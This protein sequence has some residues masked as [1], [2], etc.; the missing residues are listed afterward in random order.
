MLCGLAMG[1]AFDVY[2]VACHRFSV[3]RWTLPGLDV[4]YWALAT[5]LVFRTL[6]NNNEGEV[7]LYVFLGIGIGITGYFGLFSSPLIKAISFL[8]RVVQNT[9]RFLWRAVLV[10]FVRPVQFVV[11]MI[12]RV[13]DIAFIIVAALLLW[14]GRLALKPLAPP[15]RWIWRLLLP[16]RQALRPVGDAWRSFRTKAKQILDILRRKP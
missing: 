2:R 9:L 4:V 8:F 15:G 11:R 7:R 3:R 1:F 6:L 12:A 10:I 13:L 5:L 14:L 16:V